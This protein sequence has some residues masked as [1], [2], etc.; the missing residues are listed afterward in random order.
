VHQVNDQVDDLN[1][2][3]VNDQVDV[4]RI[5]AASRQVGGQQDSTLKLFQTEKKKIH[6][7][8]FLLK[9][10]IKLYQFISL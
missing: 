3:Q 2:Y 6:G 8:L 1:V 7:K 4:L 5:D 10:S 9:D